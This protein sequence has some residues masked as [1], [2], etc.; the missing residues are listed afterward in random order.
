LDPLEGYPAAPATISPERRERIARV[1][2]DLVEEASP[3]AVEAAR[4][5][6][7][8]L[9]AGDPEWAPA[10][11]LG[12]Q[13]DF[14]ADEKKG[15]VARLLPGGDAPPPYPASQ[16]LLGRT[17]ELLGDLPLAY[18]AYRAV[19]AKSALALRRTGELHPRVIE[20]VANRLREALKD[21]RLDEAG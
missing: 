6:A 18:S 13:A 11:V 21:R 7:R 19:A 10:K 1:H 20:I 3:E 12:A 16:M 17:A 9:A 2:R 8:D 14:V 15:I 4:T 5:L